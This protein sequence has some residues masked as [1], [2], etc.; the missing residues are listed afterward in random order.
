M[1]TDLSPDESASNNDSV[2]IGFL[3]PTNPTQLSIDLTQSANTESTSAVKSN[4]VSTN[5]RSR[6]S[7]M[8]GSTDID[9][10]PPVDPN[11]VTT[12]LVIFFS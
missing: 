5:Q 8:I 3:I 7:S 11:F 1:E 12:E 10:T 4:D 2:N 6:T 9:T